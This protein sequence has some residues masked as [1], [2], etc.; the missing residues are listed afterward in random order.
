[1]K[2]E[3][4]TDA[5]LRQFL[6]GQ[7][8]DDVRQRIESLFLTDSLT[9][10]RVLAA[11]QELI[12]DYVE[13]CLSTADRERFISIYGDTAAQQR[14]LRIAKSIQQWAVNQPATSGESVRAMSVWDRLRAR[15]VSKSVVV[16]PIAVT[17]TVAIV[18]GALWVNSRRTEQQRRYL[19][20]QQNL[21]QL[22]APSS[23]R[24]VPP[25]MSLMTLK[26]GSVRSIDSP[27]ELVR[28]PDLRIVELRL[29]WTQKE[30]YPTYQ[31]VVR[32]SGDD[33]PYT[34]P[35]LSAEDKVI[36]LRLYTDILMRGTYQIEL[37][38]VAADG[39]K[40]PPEVDNPEVYNFT[41]S[42]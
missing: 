7:V 36:R 5:V 17:A 41:V 32:G 28:R 9:K 21:A 25:Q 19:A 20:I 42:E 31:A 38:G 30:D 24:E 26:P 29:L 22:N 40:S 15:F 3:A 33:E 14:K 18:V 11:E 27:S 35:N 13:D 2:E 6:L 34:I 10:E 1:M 12:D 4:A 8:D 23:L 16:I 39:T 37:I